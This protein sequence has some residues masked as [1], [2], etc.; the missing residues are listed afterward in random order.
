MLRSMFTAISSLNAHQTWMDVIGNNLANV[1]TTGYKTSFVRFQDQISQ[2]LRPGSSPTGTRG[3][4]DPMQVGLGM[5]VGS[6]TQSFTQGAL[7]AT[8]RL[9]DLAVQGDGF[10]NYRDAAGTMFYSRDGSIDLDADG[11]LVN[12]NTG[13]RLQGWLP[14]GTPPVINTGTT[15]TDI[16]IPINST[17]A[18]ETSELTMRGNL[19]ALQ[20]AG[21]PVTLTFGVYDS[22]GALHN[23]DVQATRTGAN[24]WSWTAVAGGTGSGTLTFDPATG[25]LAT[26]GTGTINVAASAAGAQA[27]TFDVDFTSLTQLETDSSAYAAFQDGVAAGTVT[28]YAIETKTGQVYAQYSNGLQNLVAQLAVTS[29]VNPAG[30]VKV[31]QNLYQQGVN[32]GEPNT[33]LPDSNG[34]GAVIPGSVEASNVDLSQE[35][36]NMILAQRG[37]QASSRVITTSD[38]MLQELVNLKR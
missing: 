29:F 36:T 33:G 38:E 24:A 7:T 1:N 12:T 10:F 26:G 28:G 9:G 8:G 25:A 6:I 22:F 27:F 32:A 35:F 16:R 37:F 2:L 19:N 21:T 23:V 3:G 15:L 14:T 11:Y 13:Y 31:G 5:R 30:L 4:V 18:R 20:P 34:R 17:L